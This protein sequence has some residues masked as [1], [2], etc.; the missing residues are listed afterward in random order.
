MK[1]IIKSKKIIALILVSCTVFSLILSLSS[2]EKNKFSFSLND[3]GNSY[4]VTSYTGT[5]STVKIPEKYKKLPVTAIGEE[6]FAANKTMTNV[7]IPDSV[8]NINYKAFSGCSNLEDIEFSKNITVIEAGA[9]ENCTKLDTVTIPEGVVTV[10]DGAFLGCTSLS[11]VSLPKSIDQ[12]SGLAFI[13]CSSLKSIT[14]NSSHPYLTVS[15]GCLINKNTKTLIVATSDAKIPSDA[16]VTT[17]GNGAFNGRN[18]SYIVIPKSVTSVGQ[19]AIANCKKL[20]AVYY[21]GTESDYEAVTVEEMNLNITVQSLYFYSESE[22]TTDGN[23][24]H[25]VNG[26][27]VIWQ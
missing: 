5:K 19:F 12:I 6:A 8:T 1:T 22:P 4:T 2:C 15:D 10:S 26:L 25:Y 27:P 3:D 23:F 9:F 21:C 20:S 24:W 14:V 7:V 17:I 11:S 13:G 18:I 16:S